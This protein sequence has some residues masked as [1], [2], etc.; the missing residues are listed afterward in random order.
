MTFNFVQNVYPECPFKSRISKYLD[1]ITQNRIFYKTS[2]RTH[3]KCVVENIQ[4]DLRGIVWVLKMIF[5]H[6]LTILIVQNFHFLENFSSYSVKSARSVSRCERFEEDFSLLLK[7]KSKGPF[8]YYVI[9]NSQ[10]FD[11]PPGIFFGGGGGVLK[12]LI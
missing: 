12:N 2:S 11:P 7:I 1:C 5:M 3:Q 8:L 6:F 4:N 9:R 10:I